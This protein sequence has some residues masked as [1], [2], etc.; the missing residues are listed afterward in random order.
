MAVLECVRP[1]DTEGVV[2]IDLIM[3]NNVENESFPR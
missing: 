1:F 2:N 3:E